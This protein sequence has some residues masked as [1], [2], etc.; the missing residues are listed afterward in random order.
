MTGNVKVA[1]QAINEARWGQHVATLPP[2]RW[3]HIGLG[4]TPSMNER[5]SLTRAPLRTRS[6]VSSRI[7]TSQN[8]VLVPEDLFAS[9]P[10]GRHK[11][12]LC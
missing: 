4:I 10:K 8:Q 2:R 6:E 1:G 7:L 5:Q 12:C 11:I 3:V 9:T